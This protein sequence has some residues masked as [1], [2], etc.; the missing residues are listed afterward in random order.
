[1]AVEARHLNLFP[2]QLIPS[3]RQMLTNP[4]DAAMLNAYA[5]QPGSNYSPLPLSAATT[6]T[7]ASVAP[8][9]L[10]CSLSTALKSDNSTLT[11]NDNVVPA[12]RK[13]SRDAMH[14]DNTRAFRYPYKNAANFSFLGEDISLQIHRQQL[15]LDAL[16]SQHMEKVRVELEEKRKRH[17]RR[18]MEAI[19]VEMA[20]KL[21]SKEEEI[22]KIEKLN[23]ALEEKVRSLCIENQIWR[24]LAQTNEA[25]ANAL[26]TNLDQVLAQVGAPPPHAVAEEGYAESCCGSSNEGWRTVAAGAQDK[27]VEGTSG[28]RRIKESNNNINN[29][30]SDGCGGG[31]RR[32]CRNCGKEESCVL[33]LPCRHL[34]VC[35]LCGSGLHACPVC[36]S[37]KNASVH[38]NLTS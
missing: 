34:C 23:W 25:T 4:M 24:D 32:L 3:N 9:P 20:K 18:L 15:H 27:E 26:R 11:R 19:E 31:E 35:T 7:A 6:T 37:F 5:A 33:I 36:R 38:V 1:M 16:I 21:K 2:P 14:D 13:R 29:S 8:P 12:S 30:N 28:G 17:A 22:L 10:Y